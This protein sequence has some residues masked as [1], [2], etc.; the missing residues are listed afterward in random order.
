MRKWFA[1]GFILLA[2]IFIFAGCGT[3]SGARI[4]S[5]GGQ[6]DDG[7]AIS[8]ND[9]WTEE[10]YNIPPHVVKIADVLYLDLTITN[11]GKSRAYLSFLIR[12]IIYIKTDTGQKITGGVYYKANYE[13]D[14]RRLDALDLAPGEKEDIIMRFGNIPATGWELFYESPATGKDVSLGSINNSQP[15]GESENAASSE[16]E[17]T[18]VDLPPSKGGKYYTPDDYPKNPKTPGETMVAFI[19]LFREGKIKEASKL[20][21]PVPE[22]IGT[23]K[24]LESRVKALQ[25]IKKVAIYK[26]ETYPNGE[27][28]VYLTMV[29]NQGINELH[30]ERLVQV[31]GKWRIKGKP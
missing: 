28:K 21:Y 8:V 3:Q 31:G 10:I 23:A 30:G 1:L 17:A 26:V 2:A 14:K 16:P 12:D 5:Q 6:G 9:S 24:E 20:F 13:Q 22:N 7:I 25:N 29:N 19:F 18:N 15:S 11:K 27:V 4:P